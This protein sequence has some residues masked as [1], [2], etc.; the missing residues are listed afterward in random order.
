MLSGLDSCCCGGRGLG[1]EAIEAMMWLGLIKET[2][3]QTD[4]LCAR[5]RRE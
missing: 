5:P 3:D 2:R 1:L 4:Y